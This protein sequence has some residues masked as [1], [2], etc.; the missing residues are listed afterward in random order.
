ML[1]FALQL[2]GGTFYLFNKVFFSRAERNK[3][4]RRRMWKIQAWTMYLIGLPAWFVIL[5]LQDNF[6]LAGAEIGGGPAMVLGLI[7]ALRGQ[8][9]KPAWL[10]FFD[11][12]S[13]GVAATVG[14]IYSVNFLGG[15]ESVNQI[16]EFGVIAG[17]LT[18][19]VLLARE[20]P[21]GYLWFLLMN[22]S[23]AVLQYR[24]GAYFLAVQQI[25]SIA[26]VADAYLMERRETQIQR[27]ST[28]SPIS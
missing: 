23:N 26:F 15:I 21:K 11:I 14:T 19:T 24:E 3:G 4:K 27:A 28:P 16:L 18:G 10:K 22:G 1:H 20:Q 2:W 13:I 25:I 8:E 12:L 5:L 6:I 9:K 17:F 7:L